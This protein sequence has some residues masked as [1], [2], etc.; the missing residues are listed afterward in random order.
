[1][2]RNTMQVRYGRLKKAMR[3]NPLYI[4]LLEKYNDAVRR[5]H[6]RQAGNIRKVVIAVQ[7]AIYNEVAAEF[8][9]RVLDTNEP[10]AVFTARGSHVWSAQFW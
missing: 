9:F 1:M 6:H 3:Q 5:C 8:A 4:H 10:T 2:I 7:T